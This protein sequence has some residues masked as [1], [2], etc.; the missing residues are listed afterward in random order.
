MIKLVIFDA[1]HV[2]Y[3]AEGQIKYFNIKL[4]EFVKNNSNTDPQAPGAI[5][6]TLGNAVLVGKMSILQAHKE[7]ISRLGIRPELI[8][9]YEAFDRESF[10][11]AKLME[12]D[13]EK[14]LRDL[15]IR[16]YKLAVLSDGVNPADTKAQ[17]L[18]IV[19]LGGIFDKIFVSSD[20]GHKKPDSETY[21]AVMDAFKAD[22][23][24]T[25]FVGHDLDELEGAIALG[26]HTISYN[27][28]RLGH[29]ADSFSRINEIIYS[30]DNG[31]R[32]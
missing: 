5:W 28:D 1:E 3:N 20:I 21:R 32:Q 8:E 25:V 15:K 22:S 31:N 30:L 27:G 17:I 23:S 19:G 9:E 7:F 10:N 12:D 14:Y 18:E 24:E 16:N 26:I 29:E 2:L 6:K 13:E 11:Y 4:A